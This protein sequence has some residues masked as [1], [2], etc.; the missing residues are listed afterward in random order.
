MPTPLPQKGGSYVRQP[1]GQ[2]MTKQDHDAAQKAA[3]APKKAVS[4][5]KET[6]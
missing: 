4:P 5:E 3:R 1:D 6:D 2:L